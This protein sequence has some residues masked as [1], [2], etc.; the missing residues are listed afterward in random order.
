[1]SDHT[2]VS[3]EL[4]DVGRAFKAWRQKYSRKA[5]PQDLWQKAI[6][7]VSQLGRSTV[8][9]QTGVSSNYLRK[10]VHS[11]ETLQPV[12]CDAPQFLELKMPAEELM[13]SKTRE[14]RA[15]LECPDGRRTEL[16]FSGS[17]EDLL[18][19]IH[20]FMGGKQCSS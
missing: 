9:R 11:T 6:T 10:K 13:T 4:F 17:V 1:M 14:V 16:M 18:P 2:Q 19:L 7:L 3:S 8:A 5:Y 15:V 12:L 20:D